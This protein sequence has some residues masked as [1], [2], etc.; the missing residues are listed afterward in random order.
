MAAAS[1]VMV[2]VLLAEPAQATRVCIQYL[3]GYRCEVFRE[4][5]PSAPGNTR[6]MTMTITP[7]VLTGTNELRVTAGK[8]TKGEVVRAWVYN[9]FGQ[10][11]MSALTNVYEA[12][13]KGRV[14]F[15]YAPS[16]ALYEAAWG[17]PYICMRGERSLKLACA[18]FSVADESGAQPTP[19]PTTPTTPTSPT[20]KPS[21]S[22][23]PG[24]VDAGFTIICTN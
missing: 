20:P 23:A 1:A 18:P 13:S 3:D 12:N 16:T 22:L 15:V 21:G 7:E 9:I 24:C 14:S 11:R 4:P 5:T 17:Q 6:G 8:F 2:P 19:A 10:Q